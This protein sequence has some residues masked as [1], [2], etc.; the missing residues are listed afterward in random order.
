MFTMPPGAE[1]DDEVDVS[2]LFPFEHGVVTT[3]IGRRRTP[4]GHRLVRGRRCI[5]WV[6][7]DDKG[8]VFGAPAAAHLNAMET[9]AD[10][11]RHQAQSYT[12]NEFAALVALMPH[13]AVHAVDIEGL[14]SGPGPARRL[15]SRSAAVIMAG[16]S[17][18]EEVLG[19]L[20]VDRGLLIDSTGDLPQDAT[21]LATL[22]ADTL[23]TRQSIMGGLGLPEEGHWSLATPQGSVLLASASDLG[24]GVWTTAG[25]DHR[26]LLH[27]VSSNVAGQPDED[28]QVGHLPEGFVLREGKSGP[29]AILSMLRVAGEEEVYGHLSVGAGERTTAVVLLRGRPVGMVSSTAGTLEEAVHD[30]TDRARVA[31]LHQLPL[32][33]VIGEG[34]ANV[35]G[36]TLNAFGAALSTVRTRSEA[37]K[38]TLSARFEDLL[39]FEAGLERIAPKVTSAEQMIGQD[40]LE[41][42]RGGAL[43]IDA[44]YRQRLEKAEY[45]VDELERESAAFQARL[46]L[47]EEAR[48]RA[49]VS[50]REALEARGDGRSKIEGLGHD[51]DRLK[52]DAA[53]AIAR[54]ETAENRADR[55]VRRTTELE[56]QL[57]S[58]AGELARA[59]ADSSS[60]GELAA[61]IQRMAEEEATLRADL[62]TDSERLAEVRR[63]LE[64]DERHLSMLE[65]Q[66]RASHE[67]Q[68]A[69]VRDLAVAEDAVRAAKADLAAVEAES[70]A[71]RRRADDELERR[72][73]DEVRRSHLEGELRELLEERRRVLRELGD[74]GVKR[75]QSEAEVSH[76]A[77]QAEALAEAHE[78]ALRDI[79]E[80]RVLRARLTQEPLAQALLEDGSAMSALGPILERL[81]HT[82]EQGYS[83]ALLDRA[84]ERALHVVQRVVDHAAETPKHLLS[85]DVMLLLE[86]QVPEAAGVVR[87][88]TRWSVQ[89]RLDHSLN[90]VVT[91]VVLD[92]EHLLE[93]Q[94]RAITM[95]RRT[96][97]VLEQLGHLGAPRGELDALLAQCRRPESLPAT[98]KATHKLI[99]RALD[100]IH[101]EAD[102]RNAGEAVALE[103][104]AQALEE[105][106]TQLEAAGLVA[107]TPQGHL[108]SFM[109]SGLLPSEARNGLAEAP[110]LEEKAEPEAAPSPAPAAQAAKVDES[111][112]PPT[113]HP[114]PSSAIDDGEERRQIDAELASLDAERSP[115]ARLSDL[116]S[117]A[118]PALEALEARLGNID[119]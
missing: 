15:L 66:S 82:R 80:A 96:R 17:A 71:A 35:A 67:R 45:R 102:Q 91:D 13:A 39:G 95:L 110:P 58:R 55:L 101:L 98:A 75:G 49:E 28:G 86:R 99:R 77:E 52:L 4:S 90:D 43:V 68:A 97:N 1:V 44:G 70:R 47:A 29:D 93:D 85:D 38:A 53:N 81:E 107:G 115:H 78:S 12:L 57:E 46:K 18:D 25:A 5:G 31:R 69:A 74:L 23:R 73:E 116:K 54:A 59:L 111:A 50:E 94:D 41:V 113:S 112:A 83:V 61:S 87:G 104:T 72:R 119:L 105:L 106:L 32:D 37:R 8:L 114:A 7:E 10:H 88:L 14:P 3:W 63:R 34:T 42:D 62:Q 36:F 30:L 24:L 65:D 108:W 92:L 27:R 117:S 19:A 11:L 84:V 100:D 103:R 40:T 48:M 6:A 60:R 51:V 109:S 118:D 76:L 20:L 26:R 56:H 79:D 22:V 64:A 16:L 2:G 89:Q 33:A 21:A 9:E